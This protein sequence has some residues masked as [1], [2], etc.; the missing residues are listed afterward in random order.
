VPFAYYDRLSRRDRAIYD[1]SDAV[2]RLT[3]PG[4]E[5]LRPLVDRLHS[6]L[7]LDDRRAVEI[8]ATELTLR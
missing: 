6:A 8:S 1:Q 3:L 7:Q 4:A 5:E 2:V